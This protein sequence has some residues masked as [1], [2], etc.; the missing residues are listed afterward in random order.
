MRPG[1]RGCERPVS[2]PYG[3]FSSPHFLEERPWLQ[4]QDAYSPRSLKL[5]RDYSCITGLSSSFHQLTASFSLFFYPVHDSK[6][7]L[8]APRPKNTKMN[9][10]E[11]A[12]SPTPSQPSASITA[13]IFMEVMMHSTMHL[14]LK[15]KVTESTHLHSWPTGYMNLQP[16]TLSF[17]LQ[18][19]TNTK[20][21]NRTQGMEK[22]H[23]YF[24]VLTLHPRCNLQYFPACPLMTAVV[25]GW[26][27]TVS[28]KTQRNNGS[29]KLAAAGR[30]LSEQPLDTNQRHN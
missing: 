16:L 20:N 28:V 27:P 17:E 11:P 6:S 14:Q 25:L 22:K 9:H 2:A 24:P 26:C 3:T 5:E 8:S 18:F 23:G 12:L 29:R 21:K 30:P 1:E 4:P 13:I 7:S 19:C 15:V 10:T